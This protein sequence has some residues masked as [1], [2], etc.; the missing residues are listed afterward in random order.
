MRPGGS[1]LY[2]RPLSPPRAAHGHVRL[3]HPSCSGQAVLI[4]PSRAFHMQ[5][6]LMTSRH[7]ALLIGL[8]RTR[9]ACRAPSSLRMPCSVYRCT[10]YMYQVTSVFQAWAHHWCCLLNP[11]ASLIEL[12]VACARRPAAAVPRCCCVL[13]CTTS[14]RCIAH[15]RFSATSSVNGSGKGKRRERCRSS[16]S[17]R[18]EQPRESHAHSR[19]EHRTQRLPAFKTILERFLESGPTF[20]ACLI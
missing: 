12:L 15:V 1:G 8:S 20:A 14:G 13:L 7:R 11:C 5:A 10:V 6:F 3:T 16:L 19:W 2:D 17:R 9:A 18:V 4:G